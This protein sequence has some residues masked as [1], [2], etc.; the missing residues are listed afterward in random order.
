M[1][2]GAVCYGKRRGHRL[3]E[4]TQAEAQQHEL[5][6]RLLAYWR[7]HALDFIMRPSLFSEAWTPPPKRWWHP[8]KRAYRRAK[9]WSK[10]VWWAL[11]G[12]EISQD[13][14]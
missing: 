14:C 8:V 7:Q 11:R 9:N 13:D 1:R 2:T 3:V 6:E 4:L 12:G 10:N 5:N